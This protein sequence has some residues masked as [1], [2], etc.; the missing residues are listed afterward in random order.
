MISKERFFDEG[1][2]RFLGILQDGTFQTMAANEYVGYDVSS[3]GK[4]V[5]PAEDSGQRTDD[6]RQRTEG[7]GQSFEFG[8]RKEKK[9]EN[10]GHKRTDGRGQ[11]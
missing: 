7:R 8:I 11:N 4:M 1:I 5:F 10:I 6:R 2:Q 3:S 9:K